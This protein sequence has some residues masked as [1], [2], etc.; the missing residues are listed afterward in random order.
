MTVPA[1]ESSA[2]AA[3]VSR[4]IWP[5]SLQATTNRVIT[6]DID[7]MPLSLRVIDIA[8]QA[9]EDR[10]VVAR[11]VLEQD[12]QFPICYCIATINLWREVFDNSDD[13]GLDLNSLTAKTETYS[14]AHGGEGW[15]SDQSLL[16]EKLTAWEAQGGT[17]VRLTDV[18]TGHRRLDRTSPMIQTFLTAPL[19]ARQR[20][21]DFHAYPPSRASRV[22]N[23]WLQYWVDR[24]NL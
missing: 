16:Y 15:F 19:A 7:M 3:Q 21:T 1:E 10:F 8:R 4:I 12:R 2:L 24:S 20:W 9:S 23:A 17:I 11:N 18:E 14:G 13:F 22:L 5:G 6:T